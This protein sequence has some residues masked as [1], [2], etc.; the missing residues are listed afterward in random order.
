[1]HDD[2]YLALCKNVLRACRVECK[3]F[4]S[5]LCYQGV[6]SVALCIGVTECKNIED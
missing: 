6:G 2:L 1:M 3:C 5:D 4:V